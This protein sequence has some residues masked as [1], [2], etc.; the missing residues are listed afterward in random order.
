MGRVGEIKCSGDRHRVYFRQGRLEFPDHD[1]HELEKEVAAGQF[2]GRPDT[3][4]GVLALAW[5]HP[6][7]RDPDPDHG[8][9]TTTSSPATSTT[10]STTTTSSPPPMP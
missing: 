7:P 1:P 9:S 4:C 3:R 10:S 8:P 6:A 2:G 5:L